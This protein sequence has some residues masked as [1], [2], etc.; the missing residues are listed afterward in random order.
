MILIIWQI[1]T[2]FWNSISKMKL[3]VS[4]LDQSPIDIHGYYVNNAAKDLPASLHV[5]WD[6]CDMVNVLI[7]YLFNPVVLNLF[8]AATPSN[9]EFLLAT[10]IFFFTHKQLSF[11]FKIHYWKLFE[12]VDWLIWLCLIT[13][14]HFNWSNESVSTVYGLFKNLLWYF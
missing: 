12:L 14:T 10:H 11:S 6:A 3:E 1:F 5:E 13:L 2:G 7:L 9:S 4:K 8:K